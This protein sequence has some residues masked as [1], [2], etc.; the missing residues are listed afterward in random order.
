MVWTLVHVIGKWIIEEHDL[1]IEREYKK[2]IVIVLDDF[3]VGTNLKSWLQLHYLHLLDQLIQWKRKRHAS[4]NNEMN[5]ELVEDKPN[6][7]IISKR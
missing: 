5:K 4:M 6:G 1:K 3:Y 2:L 7:E